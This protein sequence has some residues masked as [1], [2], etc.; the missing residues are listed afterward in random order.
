M[1]IRRKEITMSII[2]EEKNNTYRNKSKNQTW[3]MFSQY[4]TTF[5]YLDVI[6]YFIS[7]KA[8]GI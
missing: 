6:I 7:K 2:K 3:T 5:T 1:V 4:L 8:Y